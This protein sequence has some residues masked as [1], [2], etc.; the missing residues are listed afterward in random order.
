MFRR[1]PLLQFISRF[2]AGGIAAFAFVFAVAAL[3][4]AEPA[5]AEVAQGKAIFLKHCQVCHPNG[6]QGTGPSLKLKAMSSFQMK[7]QIRMG[8]NKMPA[9]P[10]QQIPKDDLARLVAYLQSLQPKKK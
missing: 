9:F 3:R 1:S 5:P 7:T 2:Q 10:K 4:A 6:N 8:K